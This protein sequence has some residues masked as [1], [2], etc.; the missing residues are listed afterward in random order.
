MKMFRAYLDYVNARPT[1][2]W[3]LCVI[4][5]PVSL[6][7]GFFEVMWKSYFMEVPWALRQVWRERPWRKK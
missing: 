6:V 5:I 1:L 4:L 7:Y 3:C 2:K